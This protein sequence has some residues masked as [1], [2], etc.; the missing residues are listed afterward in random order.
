MNVYEV[1]GVE[2]T[3]PHVVIAEDTSC[4]EWVWRQNRKY[5][6]GEVESIKLLFKDVDVRRP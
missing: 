3:E 6:L 1:K 2:Y 5:Q 4:A